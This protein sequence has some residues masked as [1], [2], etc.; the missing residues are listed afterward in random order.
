MQK[1]RLTAAFPSDDFTWVAV[2]C[3]SK[4]DIW[5][6]SGNLI[7][8]EHGHVSVANI[9]GLLQ[10]V[11]Q[12]SSHG[13]DGEEGGPHVIEGKDERAVLIGDL[14]LNQP[15]LSGDRLVRHF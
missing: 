5:G 10:S 12:P 1:G 6:E 14:V 7:T 2:R 13:S 15:F 8:G 9:E 3:P 11:E 4:F